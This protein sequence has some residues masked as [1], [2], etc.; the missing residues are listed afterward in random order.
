MTTS[1][2]GRSTGFSSGGVL[3]PLGRARR[4]WAFRRILALLIGR[5][6][7]VR[8]ASSMLGYVWAVLDPL[9]LSL[10]Y[11]FLFTQVITRKV[12][13]PPYILFLVAGQLAWQ[14]INGSINT[15]VGA[16]RSESQMVRSSNVPRELWVLRVVLSKGVEYLFGLPVLA[17]FAVAYTKAPNHYILYFPLAL[18]MAV[19]LCTGIGL[20]LAPAAV[21]VRDLRS[22]VRIVTRALFFL[23]PILYSLQDVNGEGRRANIRDIVSWNPVAGIMALIR[24]P[25]F[26][27]ELNW[28][29][30]A[31]A[32]IVS[33]VIFAIGVWSFN[34]LE[35]PMLKEV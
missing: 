22:V 4:V 28:A 8:Y 23:S 33:V 18:L 9:A 30:V 26:A 19:V 16:L 11:W 17:L 24:A 32:A 15:C 35:R 20:I 31:H 34:R 6:L 25:F 5:D 21:L 10:V 2:R 27:E 14:W 3:N 13:F 7:R 29:D 1:I 12:G